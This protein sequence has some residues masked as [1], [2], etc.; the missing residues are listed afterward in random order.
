MLRRF[1]DIL[2]NIL[3]KLKP[4]KPIFEWIFSLEAAV[5]SRWASSAYHRL[6]TIQWVIPPQPN[7]FDHH[8]D[9]YYKWLK[10]RSSLWLERG[11]FGTL[12][13]SGGDVLELACGDG[14]YA[15]NFYSL[16]SRRIIA[17]DYDPEVIKTAKKK[18]SSPNVEFLLADIRTDMPQGKYD[19]VVF[20][21]AIDYFTLSEINKTMTDIKERL[22]EK[23]V[24]N[25]YVF[26]ER[27]SD[28]NSHREYKTYKFYNKEG[29]MQIL[30]PHFKNVI[31]FETTYSDRINLYFWASDGVI[32]FT[33][34]WP[35][36]I[37][38]KCNDFP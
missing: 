12:A 30:S 10:S 36:F 22:T 25:G 18:N 19:N 7:Y 9:L 32:P 26:V 13:L 34:S 17:C 5:A 29:L 20:D 21:A 2:L 23:G 14:F 11:V 6:M 1:K 3:K 24:F 28:E 4:L 37:S 38:S 15:R 33:P 8:I 16:R 35:H 31:V 27:K